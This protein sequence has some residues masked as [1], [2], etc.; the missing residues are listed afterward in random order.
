[1]YRGFESLRFLVFANETGPN[2]RPEK[3]N[4][5]LPNKGLINIYWNTL[6]I[7]A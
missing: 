5:F 2:K 7:Y 3:V 4:D 1:M 6:K